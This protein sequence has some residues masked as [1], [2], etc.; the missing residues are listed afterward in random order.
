MATETYE[1]FT[2]S[3]KIIK[4]FP[5]SNNSWAF[6]HSSNI[7]PTCNCSVAFESLKPDEF[8]SQYSFW[9]R[10]NNLYCTK[11]NNGKNYGKLGDAENDGRNTSIFSSS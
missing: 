10:Q 1:H 3:F 11:E 9:E 2:G 7:C 6:S 4:Q 5:V 8:T